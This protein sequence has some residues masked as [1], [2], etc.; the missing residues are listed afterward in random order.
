MLF[1]TS[2]H[3]LYKELDKKINAS[4][5]QESSLVLKTP[6]TVETCYYSI[7]ISAVDD[8]GKQRNLEEGNRRKTL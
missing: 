4:V 7:G 5:S 6:R 1:I 3:Q 2:K 8:A